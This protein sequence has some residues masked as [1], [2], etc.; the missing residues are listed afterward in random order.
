VDGLPYV[1]KSVLAEQL[2]AKLNVSEATVKQHLKPSE[3]DRFIG[4]LTVAQ[5]VEPYGHGWVIICPEMGSQMALRRQ[6]RY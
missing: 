1:S 6:E 4:I 3:H 5:I 2:R